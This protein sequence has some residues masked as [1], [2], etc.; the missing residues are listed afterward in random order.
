MR[1]LSGACLSS[2]L[3]TSE[4]YKWRSS[5]KSLEGSDKRGDSLMSFFKLL[6]VD[7]LELSNSDTFPFPARLNKLK[8]GT[9]SVMI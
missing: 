6:N 1:D 4:L 8:V 3:H 5:C 7:S 2:M 9:D